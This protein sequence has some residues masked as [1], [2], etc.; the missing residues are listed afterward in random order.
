MKQKRRGLVEVSVSFLDV[1]SCG[2]GA[3]VLLLIVAPIGD[4]SVLQELEKQL[5]G[6]V[7]QLQQ[8]LFTIRGESVVL[9]DTLKSRKQQLSHSRPI[10][11]H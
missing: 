6:S 4:P 2:F 10:L 9:N 1:I 7:A 5:R 11:D 8:Q 3:I